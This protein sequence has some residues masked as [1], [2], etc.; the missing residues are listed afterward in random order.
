MDELARAYEGLITFKY[1]GPLAP[2][3]FVS[4]REER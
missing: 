2:H 1:L 4:F 3:S